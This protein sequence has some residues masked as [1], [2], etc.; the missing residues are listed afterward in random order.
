MHA[1]M[2]QQ[3]VSVHIL[4]EKLKV[5]VENLTGLRKRS[6]NRIQLL[7]FCPALMELRIHQD[8]CSTPTPLLCEPGLCVCAGGWVCVCGWMGVKNIERQY[9]PDRLR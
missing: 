3:Q 4:S 2:S 7:Y 5:G 8:S 6:R 9:D 1:L